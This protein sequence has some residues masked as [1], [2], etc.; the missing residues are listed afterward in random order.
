MEHQDSLS[1]SGVFRHVPFVPVVEPGLEAEE[2]IKV[3]GQGRFKWVQ[4]GEGMVGDSF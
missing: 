2:V 1:F 3:H 4:G